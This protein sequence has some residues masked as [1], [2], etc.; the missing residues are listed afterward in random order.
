MASRRGAV[1]G[2]R[3][4]SPHSAGSP[5]ALV[6]VSTQ[7]AGSRRLPSHT[8]FCACITPCYGQQHLQGN[9][10]RPTTRS[11]SDHRT[12]VF[13]RIGG[14]ALGCAVLGSALE[15]MP[16]YG[17]SRPRCPISDRARDVRKRAYHLHAANVIA[18]SVTPC[19]SPAH[20]RCQRRRTV[21]SGTANSC[22]SSP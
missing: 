12:F 3:R 9:P 11:K 15:L 17:L 13:A 5:C 20:Q 7:L 10:F 16:G 2:S 8:A 18:S 4:E 21:A 19:L 14:W 1:S 6:A 22:S